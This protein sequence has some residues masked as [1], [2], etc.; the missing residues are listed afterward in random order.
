ML[1]FVF[2]SLFFFFFFF[3]R[4]RVGFARLENSDVAALR[5]SS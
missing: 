4:Y 5:F 3:R 1:Y 2:F